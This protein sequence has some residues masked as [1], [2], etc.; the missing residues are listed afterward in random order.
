MGRVFL[1]EHTT[2]GRRAA[3]KVLHPEYAV[4][5]GVLQRFFNEARAANM[6]RHPGIIEIYDHGTAP[7]VGAYLVMEFLDGE[8][9]HKR[10]RRMRRLDPEAAVGILRRV[11]SAVGAAHAAGIIHRDLKPDNIYLVPDPDHPAGERVKVLDFGVAKLVGDGE[12]QGRKTRTGAVIGTPIYMAPEQCDG[13]KD[14]DLRADIYSLGIITYEALSGRPP[15]IAEGF[16]QL[17]AQHIGHDAPPLTRWVDGVPAS[18]ASVVH[19]CLEKDPAD[20]FQS[21]GE[22]EAALAA[23][24][25]APA[26]TIAR[27]PPPEP[28]VEAAAATE[29]AWQSTVSSDDDEPAP[30]PESVAAT[31]P[32]RRSTLSA[33]A[34]VKDGTE[35]APPRSRVWMAAA[36]IALAVATTGALAASSF[37]TGDDDPTT[38]STEPGGSLELPRSAAAATAIG[39]PGLPGTTAPAE[40]RSAV[41][42][43]ARATASASAAP[44]SS[45][46]TGSARIRKPKSHKSGTKGFSPAAV[47]RKLAA[48]TPKLQ[49]TCA[50]SKS[51]SIHVTFEIDGAGRPL[52]ITAS[53]SRYAATCVKSSLKRLTFPVPDD[54]PHHVTHDFRIDPIRGV[55]GKFEVK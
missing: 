49:R 37:F 53:G 54:P 45:A 20:R 9:L 4:R 51:V 30:D 13:A 8:D 42:G 25:G 1:A 46:A 47:E 32:D 15:F 17:I 50:E 48:M 33:A 6:V 10:L 12:L 29:L 7:D 40:P 52:E 44:G 55:D 31:A 43:T 19:K 11:A 41:A 34:G 18:L 23:S 14:I 26:A 39:V 38:G 27:V 35:P 2:I 16:G 24:V 22:L 5:Q 28:R 21:M 36:A 3:I